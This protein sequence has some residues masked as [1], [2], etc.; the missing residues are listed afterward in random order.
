MSSLQLGCRTWLILSSPSPF[1][2]IGTS[3]LSLTPEIYL[4]LFVLLEEGHTLFYLNIHSTFMER[5]QYSLHCAGGEFWEGF[6]E[7]KWYYLV[8][9]HDSPSFCL[10]KA[11]ERRDSGSL[12]VHMHPQI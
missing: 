1:C 10:E 9:A 4:P 8:I 3:I 6:G 7:F 2:A 11:F 12:R 5:L